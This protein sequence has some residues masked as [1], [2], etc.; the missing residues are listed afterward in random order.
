VEKTVACVHFHE[1]L[2][3][4]KFKFGAC[5]AASVSRIMSVVRSLGPIAVMDKG[6]QSSFT[7]NPK[8]YL[9]KEKLISI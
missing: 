3:L 1:V 6:A 5:N 7:V 8:F 2:M 9:R 4:A